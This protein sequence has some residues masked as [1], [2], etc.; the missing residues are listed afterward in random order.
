MSQ[1]LNAELAPLDSFTL[2]DV[3]TRMA[4]VLEDCG[5]DFN[6]KVTNAAN[7]VLRDLISRFDWSWKTSSDTIVTT[8]GLAEYPLAND[9]ARMIG[10]PIIEGEG[11]IPRRRLSDIRMMQARN[12][13]TGEVLDTPRLCALSGEKKITFWPTPQAEYTILYDYQISIPNL[14]PDNT[15]DTIPIPGHLRHVFY[16]MMRA[17][18]KDDDGDDPNSIIR[19]D[20]RVERMIA[21]AMIA[22]IDAE[23]TNR[24]SEQYDMV[25]DL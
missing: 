11:P 18:L 17:V 1:Q 5:D 24:S 6:T 7:E 12:S 23:T 3:Q 8:A 2:G 4:S 22:D 10:F 19:A 25:T 13:E 21:V 9:F 16:E 14:D 20:R 15:G